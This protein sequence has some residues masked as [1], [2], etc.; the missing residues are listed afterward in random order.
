MAH[1]LLTSIVLLTTCLASLPTWAAGGPDERA[2]NWH[3]WRGPEATG[4]ATNGNPPVEW[5]EEKNVK[6]KVALPGQGSGSPVVWG[7]RIYLQ[8]AIKTDRTADTP[9]AARTDGASPYRFVS[10]QET[11]QSGDNAER[12][13]RRRGRGRRGGGGGGFGGQQPTNFHQFAVVCLDRN[14]G[15]TI[16]QQV[17]AEVV[18]HQGH[19][20]TASYAS[21]SPVTDG[22]NIYVSFGSR[23]IFSYD[24]DGNLRWERQLGEMDIMF[25]FGE[26]S[27]P[28]LWN[29]TLVINW[30]HQGES[31]IT[32]LDANTGEP[33]WK[34]ARDEGTTWVS[35]LIVE[36]EGVVQVIVNGSNR[37]RSY[38][39]A[40]GDVIWECG[41]QVSAP[42]S[43]AVVHNDLVYC[44]SGHRGSAL[45]A[46]PL[47]AR[48]DI[49]DTDEVAWS[50]DEDT[51][52]VPSPL[53]YDNLLY[54]TK[55]NNAI[56]TCVAAEDGTVQYKSKRLPD[57]DTLYSS[58]VGAAGR[59]YIAARNGNTVVVKHGP[60]FEVLATNELEETIDATPAIVGDEIYVRTAG[61]L[62]CFAEE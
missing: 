1:Q 48:G 37:T 49:T 43:T 2:E 27:S 9:D 60:E 45:K 32:A 23:G 25:N 38:D 44:M 19:H 52:Y 46:I 13:E 14:T 26:G 39:L 51:P 24:M 35:P 16:W 11:A 18:P 36:H 62:Y 3:R 30:D 22:K 21:S 7:N 31:F 40:T 61:H 58:P 34:V 17:A 12:G 15:E 20:G 29:D 6:W 47:S 33:R 41:G 55:G 8:T 54:F 42:V 5:G 50:M 10:Q 56:L 28:E 53:L 4:V 57:L 59:V